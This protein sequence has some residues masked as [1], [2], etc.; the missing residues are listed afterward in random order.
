MNLYKKTDEE[1]TEAIA[2]CEH[3]SDLSDLESDLP[4]EWVHETGNSER[5]IEHFLDQPR[6]VRR[7]KC[8]ADK[9]R[10]E[11]WNTV[12]ICCVNGKHRSVVMANYLRF[13]WFHD[14]EIVHLNLF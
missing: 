9:I 13:H 2:S 3:V 12:G 10:K 6:F 4:R 8:I 1:E 11:D 5:V 14:A 7:A